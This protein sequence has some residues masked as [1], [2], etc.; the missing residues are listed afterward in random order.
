M[1]KNLDKNV[2][3][4]GAGVLL[5][6][7]RRWKQCEG[8]EHEPGDAFIILWTWEEHKLQGDCMGFL[9]NIFLYQLNWCA[10]KN[11]RISSF[12]MSSPNSSTTWQKKNLHACSNV[13]AYRSWRHVPI[14]KRH[15]EGKDKLAERSRHRACVKLNKR[16]M[17]FM[18]LIVLENKKLRRF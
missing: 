9:K 10:S 17:T 1:T 16:K 11:I 2:D 5:I 3:V 13:L 8:E 14:H 4:L 18:G 12:W 6:K 15:T 7:A